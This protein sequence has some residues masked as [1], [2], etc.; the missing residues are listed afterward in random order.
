M[1][2]K[3]YIILARFEVIAPEDDL[4]IDEVVEVKRMMTD[5]YDNNFTILSIEEAERIINPIK[6][7]EKENE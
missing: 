7:I 6:V 5:L 2:N 4:M 1:A 3:R